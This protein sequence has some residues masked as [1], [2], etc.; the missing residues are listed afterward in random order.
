MPAVFGSPA[1]WRDRAEELRV[2]AE[3]RSEPAVRQSLLGIAAR[4]EKM[5]KHAEDAVVRAAQNPSPRTLL[6]G[7]GA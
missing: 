1:R 3:R 7:P 2:M 6:D 5:A 4:Y